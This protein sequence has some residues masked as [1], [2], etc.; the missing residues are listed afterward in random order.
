MMLYFSFPNSNPNPNS[1]HNFSEAL[2]TCLD[3]VI[4]ERLLTYSAFQK[5]SKNEVAKSLQFFI[6]RAFLY[7]PM[8]A[9]NILATTS[10]IL[11]SKGC[12][13]RLISRFQHMNNIIDDGNN[14]F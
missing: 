3:A 1:S 11:I 5:R 4:S 9:V 6:S 2:T 7:S 12:L 8:D 10:S 13:K 14:S